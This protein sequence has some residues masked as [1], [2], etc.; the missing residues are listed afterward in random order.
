MLLEMAILYYVA[1]HLQVLVCVLRKERG[2]PTIKQ[3]TFEIQSTFCEARG[4]CACLY[5]TANI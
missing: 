2:K 5:Y 4:I 1:I 3:N